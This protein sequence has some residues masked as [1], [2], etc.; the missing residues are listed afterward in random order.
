MESIWRAIRYSTVSKKYSMHS[1]FGESVKHAVRRGA[2]VLCACLD[3]IKAFGKVLFNGVCVQLSI[4]NVPLLFYS[5]LSKL[6]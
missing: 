2:N 6:V 5:Y 4:R 1:A 3:D